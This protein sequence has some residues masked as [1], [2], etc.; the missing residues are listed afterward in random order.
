MASLQGMSAIGR[1]PCYD[2]SRVVYDLFPG[3][4]CGPRLVLWSSNGPRLVPRSSPPAD[5]VR[6][7]RRSPI[8]FVRLRP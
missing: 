8:S 4:Q 7:S 1:R 3:A 6:F 5:P 2:V